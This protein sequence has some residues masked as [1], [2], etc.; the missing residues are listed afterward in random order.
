MQE[1]WRKN[2]SHRRLQTLHVPHSVE[3]G[4]DRA[5]G[6]G[7]KV[8]RGVD[9]GVDRKVERGVGREEDRMDS[10]MDRDTG[11][12][13]HSEMGSVG[14]IMDREETSLDKQMGRRDSVGDIVDREETSMDKQMSRAK[15]RAGGRSA[16]SSPNWSKQGLLVRK[17]NLNYL[18]GR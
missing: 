16:T 6:Q 5:D 13:V 7:E 14:D 9:R 15:E 1:A 18:C 3:R 2:K 17:F 8:D 11:R 10:E 4:V 12:D